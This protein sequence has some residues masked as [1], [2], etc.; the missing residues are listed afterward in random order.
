MKIKGI[1][2]AQAAR[3]AKSIGA[4]LYN[5]RPAGKFL[6]FVIRPERGPRGERYRARGHSG[7][8]VWAV[9]WHGH[10]VFMDKLF[11]MNPHVLIVSTAARYEGLE[12]YERKLATGG[13]VGAAFKATSRCECGA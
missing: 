10:K 4:V 5:V 2:E 6:A 9:C 7:R 12:D 11:T 3:A 8:R 13:M 1:T